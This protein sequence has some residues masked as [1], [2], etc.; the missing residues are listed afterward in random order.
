M[1]QQNR[2]R[3]GGAAWELPLTKDPSKLL[4]AEEA[5][6]ASNTIKLGETETVEN[7]ENVVPEG[8]QKEGIKKSSN[9]ISTDRPCTNVQDAKPTL[10]LQKFS[11]APMVEFE[12]CKVGTGGKKEMDVHNPGKKAVT[13]AIRKL[14]K[15]GTV[16][17]YPTTS[18]SDDKEAEWMLKPDER[19]SFTV[20]WNPSS[21]GK[22]RELIHLLLDNRFRPSVVMLGEA[23]ECSKKQK[24]VSS[25][26]P[27]G[28]NISYVLLITF[29]SI[30]LAYL[31]RREKL[32]K[33][34]TPNE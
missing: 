25:T 14:P 28:H 16:D 11:S 1:L 20:A 8:E 33:R 23:V 19:R 29:M 2:R 17:F 27:H 9:R 32:P 30:K 3:P 22:A 7:Q 26:L 21:T 10:L 31:H 24:T 6:E 15:Q 13:L 34:V 5:H 18:R 12:E 4:D